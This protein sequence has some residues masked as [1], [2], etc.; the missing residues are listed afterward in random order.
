MQPPGRCLDGLPAEFHDLLMDLRE[1]LRSEL[2]RRKGVNPRYSVRGLAQSFGVSHTVLVRMMSGRTRV[3]ARTIVTVGRAL[4]LTRTQVE[5][6][7]LF[8]RQALVLN[9]VANSRFRADCRWIASQSGLAV[10]DVNRTL[11]ALLSSGRIRFRT[12]TQWETHDT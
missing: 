4:K 2:S 11:F 6:A 7:L 5:S 9:C 10:D 1:L 8:E 12:S 3:S